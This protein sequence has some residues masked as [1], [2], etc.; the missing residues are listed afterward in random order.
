MA[1]YLIAVTGNVQ[2]V[3][4][5]AQVAAHARSLGLNGVA[6][7][8]PDGSVVIEACGSTTALDALLEW[9]ANGPLGVRVDTIR[10][11]VVPE[12][13]PYHGFYIG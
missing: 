6:K 7:N 9:C 11:D 2:G 13:R 1:C 5:R 10:Y 4:F 12:G 3:G 8:Q